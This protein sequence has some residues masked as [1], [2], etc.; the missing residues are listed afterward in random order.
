MSSEPC[1]CRNVLTSIILFGKIDES[2]L[3]LGEEHALA[4]GKLAADHDGADDLGLF[5][6]FHLKN[7]QTVVEKDLVPGVHLLADAL[8]G[9]GDARLVALDLLGRKCKSVPFLQ[10]DFAVPKG[11]DAEFRTFGIEQDGKRNVFLLAHLFDGCDF[12]RMIFI[13]SVREIDARDVHSGIRHGADD[14]FGLGSGSQRADDLGLFHTI[15]SMQNI[16]ILFYHIFRK[17]QAFF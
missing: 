16:S 4:V 11:L 8:V 1:S 17:K 9:N 6:F 12:F 15:S 7:H 3:L 14:F 13:S 2:E 10:K 5:D